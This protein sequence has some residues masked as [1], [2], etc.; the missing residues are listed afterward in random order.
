MGRTTRW[1]IRCLCL[2]VL[3]GLAGC[4]TTGEQEG[5]ARK[6]AAQFT[7]YLNGPQQPSLDMTFELAAVTIVAEDG[8]ARE[9]MSSPREVNSQAVSGRQVLLG[10]KVLPEGR[11]TGLELVVTRAEIIRDGRPASLALPPDGIRIN[12]SVALTGNQNTTLFLNWNADASLSEEYLF[13]PVFTVK[14]TSPELSTLLVY[15]T[16]EDSN[17]VSVINRQEGEVAASV[18]VGRKPR[19]LATA[20]KGDRLKVYVA[21]S[22]SNSISV[23]D[24][25]G[26]T[27][28]NE[29]PIRFGRQPEALAVAGIPPDRELLFVANYGSDAV[30][31][32][33]TITYQE[34]E[35]IEVG[36]GPIAIA[37]DPP[38]EELI[39]TRFL[40]FED[41]NVMRNYRERFFNVYVANH[42]S[43]TVSVIRM[44]RVR[45]KSEEVM[46]LN[47]EWRPIAVSVDYPRG[48]V[49]VANYSSD[50]LSVIDII[51][52]I[53]G[54]VD[55]AVSTISSVGLS[56]VDVIADPSFDRLYL[57]K[58]APA[59]IV[60]IRPFSEGSG[61]LKD[62]MPPVMGVVPVGRSPRAFLLDPE[63][64]KFYVVNRGADTLSIVDKTTKRE[65]A[66]IPVGRNPYGVAVFRK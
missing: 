9:V 23:I 2:A 45:R 56:I 52:T 1:A 38:A 7:L 25:T 3:A 26:N 21:N 18:M 35:K 5:F 63:G 48:K 58:E 66:V 15:V 51:E 20:K 61:A 24:P 54:N 65:E 6:Q 42:D 39:G 4:A 64:R 29:I 12:I 57:L 55:G 16:N 43:N 36:R 32:V 62:A 59:E 40:G 11:Y 14:T 50:K 60:I 44:D 10:E 22:G 49:Y 47:V 34:L 30:S 46:T 17:N 13:S 37:V 33:D 53:K 31:T 27:V 8:T 41:L 19:G 28:E